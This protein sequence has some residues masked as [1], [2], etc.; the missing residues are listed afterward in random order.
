MEGLATVV[1]AGYL[2]GLF[3][4]RS[5][6]V[7]AAEAPLPEQNGP[8]LRESP[9]AEAMLP[10]VEALLAG[11]KEELVAPI[12]DRVFSGERRKICQGLAELAVL[13][14]LVRS[15]WIPLSVA[16]QGGSLRSQR[17]DGTEIEVGVLAFLQREPVDPESLHRLE[18]ALQRVGSDRRY[19][20]FVRR[21]LPAGFNPEPVRRSVELWLKEVDAGRWPG[22]NATNGRQR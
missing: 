21:G 7:L 22:R 5:S 1:G 20:V 16:E 11:F 10:R 14:L 19:S 13:D 6:M 18:Q 3:T 9:L 2:A 17:P 4:P 15:D 8:L 12:R